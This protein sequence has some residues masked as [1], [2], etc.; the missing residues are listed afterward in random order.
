M[1]RF[2]YL[3]VVIL[4]CLV[5]PTAC[6]MP[7]TAPD[8][9]KLQVDYDWTKANVCTGFSPEI[10]VSGIPPTT[11]QLKVSVTDL[12]YLTYDHGGGTVKY[13]GSNIIPAGALK[14]FVGP[15]PPSDPHQYSIRVDA[16]DASG[17][18]IGFGEKTKPCCQ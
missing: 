1:E 5:L 6:N 9:V 4:L 3:S 13:E 8:A 16:I 17:V 18:I 12:N 2:C 11:K 15:C 10:K 14:D 7:K